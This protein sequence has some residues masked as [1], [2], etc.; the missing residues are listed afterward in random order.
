LGRGGGEALLVELADEHVQSLLGSLAFDRMV[1]VLGVTDAV[2]PAPAAL[3]PSSA[4]LDLSN[5]ARPTI[6]YHERRRPEGHMG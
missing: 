1:A 4:L 6:G 2:N 5:Q 3:G